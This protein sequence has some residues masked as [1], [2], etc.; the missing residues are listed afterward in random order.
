MEALTYLALIL[1]W[2]L[3]V[4]ALEWAFGWRSLVIEWRGLV[5]AVLMATAYLGLAGVAALNDGIWTI[6]P[7]KTLPWRGGDFVFE[8]WVFFLLTNVIIVQTVILAMDDVVRRR[9]SRRLRRR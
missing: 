9:V 7:D 1:A 6:N 2:S 8:E 5:I 3:P 4:I